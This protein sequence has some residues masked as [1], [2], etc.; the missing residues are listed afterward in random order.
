[1]GHRKFSDIASEINPER[2]ARID[3][4]KKEARVDAAG[5]VLPSHGDTDS[6]PVCQDN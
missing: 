1:M 3:A 6:G 2:R 5:C 4:L